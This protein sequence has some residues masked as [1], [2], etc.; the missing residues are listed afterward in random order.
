MK[1]IHEEIIC[2]SRSDR[3]EIFPFYDCHIGKRNCAEE[4]IISQRNE[5]L[6]RSRLPNRHVRVVLGGDI[7]DVIK[8]QDIRYDVNEVADWV[9]EGDAEDI[10]EKLNDIAK[11]QVKR[12]VK[13]FKPLQPFI[14]GSIEANHG[15]VVRK[16]YNTD[17]HTDFCEKLGID[18]L[19]DEAKIRFVFKRGCSSS[20]IKL[21]M[22]HGYGGGRT[23]GAEP[24]KIERMM[25]DGEAL[26]KWF[27]A[28]VNQQLSE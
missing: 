10:R 22:R 26:Q 28:I 2:E 12:A 11:A 4:C 24:A 25:S 8:P 19:T 17:T 27:E 6:K 18:S 9:F 3:V 13:I 15:K 7:C 16:R 1:L 14:I 5:I 21:Y 23:P 20:M